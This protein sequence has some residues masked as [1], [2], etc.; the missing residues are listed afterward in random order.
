MLHHIKP[1]QKPKWNMLFFAAYLSSSPLPAFFS[2]EK[3]SKD[4]NKDLIS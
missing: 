2:A 4:K 3:K 1:V